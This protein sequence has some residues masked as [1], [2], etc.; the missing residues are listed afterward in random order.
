MYKIY[1]RKFPSTKKSI[2]IGLHFGVEL[3]YTPSL[4]GLYN[5]SQALNEAMRTTSHRKTDRRGNRYLSE[6]INTSRQRL[7]TIKRQDVQRHFEINGSFR[8][9][10][11]RLR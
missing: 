11:R 8:C 2:F 9:G 10:C 1:T 3:T 4:F 7:L 6:N 5:I